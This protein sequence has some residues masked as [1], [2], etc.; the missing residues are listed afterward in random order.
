MLILA[1]SA[2]VNEAILTGE[3]TPQW[4]VPA[5]GRGVNEQLSIKQDKAH[6]L[7]GGTKILQHTPDKTFPLRAPDGGCLAVVLRTGFETSQGKLMRT[8][9][10]STERVTAKQLIH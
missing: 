9:L 2:I 6:V 1:G 10:F 8:I 3:S 4:K 5:A 7:F